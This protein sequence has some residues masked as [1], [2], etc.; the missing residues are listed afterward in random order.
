MRL[1][2]ETHSLM[3][4]CHLFLSVSIFSPSVQIYLSKNHQTSVSPFL[5]NL[6]DDDHKEERRSNLICFTAVSVTRLYRCRCDGAKL[7]T[8]KHPFT[9]YLSYI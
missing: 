4:A 6:L 5:H 7:L 8:L 2:S 3:M 1:E 9:P